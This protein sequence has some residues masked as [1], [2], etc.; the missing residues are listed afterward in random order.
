MK[1][2]QKEAHE[3]EYWL[4]LCKFANNY[5]YDIKYEEL[6]HEIIRIIGKIIS[7]TQS[8]QAPTT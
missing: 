5:D 3:T 7:T 1:I 4:K 8:K 2:A 6:L